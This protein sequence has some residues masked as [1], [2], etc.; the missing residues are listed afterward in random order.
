MVV[1]KMVPE[2]LQQR[3]F[4]QVHAVAQRVGKGLFQGRLNL[5]GIDL[6]VV[7]DGQQQRGVFR[8]Y[9]RQG[10]YF[11]SSGVDLRIVQGQRQSIVE[12]YH[13]QSSDK[14]FVLQK[15][16]DVDIPEGIACVL[17][18]RQEIEKLAVVHDA[19]IADHELHVLN[20]IMLKFCFVE[21][22]HSYNF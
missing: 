14:A 4:E 20:E 12:D 1:S 10:K 9:I 22:C 7:Q 16:V 21:R 11:H 17:K 15:A 8:W 19:L 2:A 13:P 5:H 3:L 6:D 18:I